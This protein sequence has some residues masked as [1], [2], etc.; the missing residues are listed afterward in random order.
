MLNTKKFLNKII[1]IIE[2]PYL[3]ELENYGVVDKKE[4]KYVFTKKFKGKNIILVDKPV[5]TVEFL[6]PLKVY[7]HNYPQGDIQH[8]I[9][10]LQNYKTD[11]GEHLNNPDLSYIYVYIKDEKRFYLVYKYK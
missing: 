5:F 4:I 6:N 8:K 11:F 2:P 10:I 7:Y 9:I 3:Q 1:K